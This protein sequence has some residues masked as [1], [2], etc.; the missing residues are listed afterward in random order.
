MNR[1]ARFS[2]V[3]A[4]CMLLLVACSPA[5][6]RADPTPQ[7]PDTG[8]TA[9]SSTA[10]ASDVDASPV[11]STAMEDAS[12]PASAPA[13]AAAPAAA[14]PVK[15]K[16]KIVTI[17]MHVAGGPFDEITKEPF[18]KTVEPHFP[19][20]AQC[21]ATKVPAAKQPKMLDVGVDLLIEAAGG[22]PKVSNPR[23]TP[24]LEDAPDFMACVIAVYESVDFAKLVDRGRTGVSYSLRFT[25]KD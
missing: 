16:V 1:P 6:K 15:A 13:K 12:A 21:W 24:K 10:R 11:A 20:I 19:E 17:G 5:Q 8:P 14:E 9:S 22:H 7:A 4:L 2:S 3:V 25:Q 18:K 23:L